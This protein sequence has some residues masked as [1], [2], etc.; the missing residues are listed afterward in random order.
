M[1][2]K[3]GL[4]THGLN[5]GNPV[6]QIKFG[7]SVPLAEFNEL[8][9][10]EGAQAAIGMVRVEEKINRVYPGGTKIDYRRSHQLSVQAIGG[11]ARKSRTIEK[12]T[13]VVFVG[14][15]IAPR[16]AVVEEFVEQGEF[17]SGWGNGAEFHGDIAIFGQGSALVAIWF[18]MAGKESDRFA[19]P[20]IGAI[21]GVNRIAV[22]P[23]TCCQENTHELR[24]KS[25]DPGDTVYGLSGK[26]VRAGFGRFDEKSF[27]PADYVLMG[28]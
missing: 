24:G 13:G 23:E 2:K 11:F 19:G 22:T 27:E 16:E 17:L 9:D 28:G 1:G 6:A 3:R 10:V 12:E 5:L 7:Q 8:Q 18:E 21:H 25:V 15:V 26:A 4:V 20:A 14:V